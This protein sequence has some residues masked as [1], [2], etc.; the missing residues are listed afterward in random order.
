M[1]K[2][3]L[4]VAYELIDKE[5][6]G[7]AFN[8][9]FEDV[10]KTLAF[11]EDEA[12]NKIANFYTN[13][14]LDGRFVLLGNNVWDLKSR[15]LSKEYQIDMASAYSSDNDENESVL[16][17]LDD[18]D[19]EELELEKSEEDGDSNDSDSNLDENNHDYNY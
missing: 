19:E 8:K 2:S 10:C 15:H 3:M 13:L 6:E 5:S 12:A 7:I 11:N 9:L 17:N 18:A 1:Q 14:T 4:D 16:D